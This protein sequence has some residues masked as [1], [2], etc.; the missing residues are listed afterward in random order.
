MKSKKGTSSKVKL[1]FGGRNNY[2]NGWINIDNNNIE[3]LDLKWDFKTPLPFK[4]NCADV[5]YDEDFLERLKLGSG[6]VEILLS[7]FRHLLKPKGLLKIGLS[8]MKHKS[9]LEPWLEKLGF[10]NLEFY[11]PTTFPGN[12]KNYI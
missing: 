12:K 3:K 1:H 10:S 2:L 5:I 8:D 11:T 4:E 6:F 7:C 9:K